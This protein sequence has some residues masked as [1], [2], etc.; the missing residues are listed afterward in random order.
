MKSFL[1]NEK[2]IFS[3]LLLVYLLSL[4]FMPFE[5]DE[6]SFILTGKMIINGR[7][8][9]L[10][11]NHK[12]PF[13]YQFGSSLV[14]IIYGAFYLVGGYYSVRILSCLFIFLSL[15]VIYKL[16]NKIF[17]KK[18][19]KIALLLAGI[20][21]TTVLLVSD[22]LL[23]SVGIFFFVLAIYLI[24]EK[25]FFLTGMSLGLSVLCKFFVAVP[26]T[27]LVLYLLKRREKVLP[28]LIGLI[29][30]LLPFSIIYYKILLELFDYFKSQ[31]YVMELGTNIIFLIVTFS[32]A[33]PIPFFIVFLN[34][35]RDFIRKHYVLIIPFLVVAIFHILTLN[36]MSL[37]HHMAYGLIPISILAGRALLKNKKISFIL[38]III[39]LNLYVIMGR[40]F[41]IPSYTPIIDDIKNLRG[42]ILAEN[43]NIIHLIKGTD[44]NDDYV[45]NFI[46]FDFDNDG[47]SS[48]EEYEEAMSKGYFDY[49]IIPTDLSWSFRGKDV[50]L[51][52]K[53]YYCRN[54]TTISFQ[55]QAVIYSRCRIK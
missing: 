29:I 43:P 40:I 42:K 10:E 37:N 12:N 18:S 27:F 51:L 35:K 49:V 2:F 48:K 6:S 8:N 32:Y 34:Y 46:Y 9:P 16:T 55:N 26:A 50:Q 15:I 22:A 4:T 28:I 38:L 1:L 30:I 53:N 31:P 20:S 7:L 33:L 36:F 39:L 5:L 17:D 21:N 19:A 54:Y 45:Y 44:L 25:K 23:D 47:K 14:P 13:T 3:F 52:V 11:L 41:I 24:Y